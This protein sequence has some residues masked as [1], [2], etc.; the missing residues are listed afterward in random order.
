MEL[1]Y[2]VIPLRKNNNSWDVLIVRRLEGFWEFPKGHAN[3]GETP[4]EA[5]ARELKE[6][7]G[8][9][10]MSLH[11]PHPFTISYIYTRDKIARHKSVIYFLGIV[12][13]VLQPQLTEVEE[14]QWV[15]LSQAESLLTHE[16]SKQLVREVI[17]QL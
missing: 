12:E 16:T 10:L 1:S 15:P 17:G 13:G 4:L 14:L 11:L 9:Q 5:A 7:T 8:L 6:E 2:G 3:P